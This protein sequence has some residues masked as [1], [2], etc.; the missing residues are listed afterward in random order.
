M[1]MALLQHITAH[2]SAAH[3]R[4]VWQSSILQ[5]LGRLGLGCDSGLADTTLKHCPFPGW[6]TSSWDSFR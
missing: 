2:Q 6:M 1:A 4:A 3:C 5:D